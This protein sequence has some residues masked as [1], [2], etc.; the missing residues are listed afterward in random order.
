MCRMLDD[1][2]TR[3]AV[4]SRWMDE[5]AGGYAMRPRYIGEMPSRLARDAPPEVGPSGA[6]PSFG[7]CTNHISWR[8]NNQWILKITRP[9]TKLV[10][11]LTQPDARKKAGNGRHYSNAIGFYI[12]RGNEQPTDYNRRKLTLDPNDPDEVVFDAEPRFTRQLIKECAEIA[13]RCDLAPSAPRRS[14]S[15]TPGRRYTFEEPSE[16]PFILL[17]YLFEAGR[18]SLFKLTI[19]SDDRDDDGEP[20]FGFQ[21]VKPEED[22]RRTTLQDSWSR[23]GE[24]NAL[25]VEDSAGGPVGGPWSDGDKPAW[26]KNW[27]YQ[28]TLPER[29][30][31]YVFLELRDID[32]DMRDKAGLQ[33]EPEWLTVGFV[34]CKGEGDHV[35]LDHA[36][37]EI[38]Q[39]AKLR[40]GDGQ[41]LDI[42]YLDPDGGDKYVIIPYV[43]TPGVEHKF[44]LTLY[45]DLEHKFEKIIPRLCLVDCVQCGSRS[46]LA[47]VF[48][49]L[50]NLEDKCAEMD[51]DSRDARLEDTC[52]ADR[53]PHPCTALRRHLHLA[54]TR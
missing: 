3:F 23:G 22:W 54:G 32:Y 50:A 30:R 4:R 11:K 47:R 33:T 13:P 26:T 48:D 17:P 25:G 2:W 45:T 28:I 40:R 44:A 43:D 29:S 20:D 19:L 24:G 10:I 34:L 16:T 9:N 36:Q 53:A 39:T 8:S 15:A 41:W 52:A 14:I 42:G 21:E 12:M 6:S 5:T 37:P 18:E 1:L 38:L 7:R 27:Q 49:K 51:R 46:G 31:C 35:K